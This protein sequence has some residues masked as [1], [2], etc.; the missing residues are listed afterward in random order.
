MCRWGGGGVGGGGW[1][2]GKRAPLDR[3]RQGRRRPAACVAAAG[4]A[5]AARG[6]RRT[7]RVRVRPPPGLRPLPRP[8]PSTH[9]PAAQAGLDDGATLLTGGKRP[10]TCPLGF[11]LEPTVFT[12]VKPHMRIWKEEIF[13]PVLSGAPHA[14]AAGRCSGACPRERKR[15]HTGAS[16]R[17]HLAARRGAR[18]TAHV[19]CPHATLP[20]HPPPPQKPP[21]RCS[22]D[23]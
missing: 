16:S 14:A 5:H 17:A 13:G 22:G 19:R 11:F 12:G 3:Q 1:L 6:W 21:L 9:P 15:W 10:P 2:G 18:R 23:V 8:N 4:G 7:W 20:T